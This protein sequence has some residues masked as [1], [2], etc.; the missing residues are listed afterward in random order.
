MPAENLW[1]QQFIQKWERVSHYRNIRG[2]SDFASLG[3]EIPFLSVY[4]DICDTDESYLRCLFLV[5]G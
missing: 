2:Q 5:P 3:L 4:S 1:S